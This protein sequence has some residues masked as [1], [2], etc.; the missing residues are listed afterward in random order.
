MKKHQIITMIVLLGI[1]IK[2]SALAAD[3]VIADWSGTGL[4]TTRPFRAAGPWEFRWS[5]SPAGVFGAWLYKF[6]EPEQPE[7]TGYD[8]ILAM[9]GGKTNGQNER[10]S[11]FHSKGEEYYIK[12]MASCDWHVQILGIS[13]PCGRNPSN[14]KPSD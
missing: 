12:I 14:A 1:I 4:G 13:R 5:C 11:S 6:G 9:T 10:G 8:D 2:S 7:G 3:T